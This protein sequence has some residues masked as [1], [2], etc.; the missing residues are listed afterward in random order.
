[1]K[2]DFFWNAWDK[3][4]KLFYKLLLILFGS[5]VLVYVLTIL[6]GSSFVINWEQETWI[7]PVKVLFA[8]YRLG[9]F[10]FPITIEN[11]A[12]SQSFV[13]SELQVNVWPAYI[14]L[15]W[16]GIFISIML[17]LITD[18]SRFWFVVSIVLLTV[19]FIGLKLDYLVLFNS[20][21][22][23]GLLVA[24]I[25]YYPALYIF[26]F[27]KKDIGFTVRFLTHLLATI[28]FGLIIFFFSNV[29]LPFF[30]VVN[31]GIYVPLVLTILFA[32]FVGHEIVSG[33]LRVITSGAMIGEKNGL[34]HFLVI[35]IVFLINA[36][37]VILRNSKILDLDIYLVGS[38][39]LLTIAAVVG[40]WGYRSR[41]ATYSGIFTFY[42]FGAFLFIGLAITA[43]FTISYF[44]ITGNDS[45]VEAIEDAIIFSQFGYSLIFVIYVIA[46]FFDLLKHNVDVGKVLYKPRRMPYFISRFAGIIVIM[47]LFFRFNMIPY[48]QSVAG[49]YAGI[50]DLYMEAKDHMSA[51]E[52]Y[53]LSNIFSNTSHRVNYALATMEKREGN[54]RQEIEFLQKAI[55]KNPTE[56]AYVNL[57]SR[58]ME[59]ERFFEAI[60]TLQDGLEKFPENGR[61][62]NNLGLVYQE[63]DNI[64][65]AYYYFEGAFY[66]D[67][68]T[69]VAAAN[70]YAMLS[71]KGLSIKYDTLDILLP[72][73]EDRTKVNN[74]VVLANNLKKSAND[75]YSI[76]FGK[77]DKLEVDQLVYN[78][79]KSINNPWL[80]DSAYLQQMQV[81]YDSSNTSW[82]QDNLRLSSALALYKQGELSKSLDLLNLLAIQ[83][84]EKGYFGLLGKLSL[85]SGEVGLAIDNF[86]NAFQNGQLEI[87]PELAFAYMEN[88]E[89]SKAEF[90]WEQLVLSGD[91]VNVATANKMLEVIK[92][93]SIEEVLET[94]TETRFSFLAYR[95]RE[96][97]LGKLEGL[98]LSFD[99]EDIQAMGFLRLFD[100]YLEL[101]QV[102]KAVDLL[103]E[104]GQLNISRQDVLEEINLA[105]CRYAY[106]TM[107]GEIMQRLYS[108]LESENQRVND[109]LSL[110]KIIEKSSTTGPQNALTEFEKLGRRNPFFEEGVIESVRFFNESIE[111]RDKAYE[112][113]LNAVNKNPFSIELNKLYAIQCLK[114]GLISYA[115][116]TK[117]ELQ[118]MMP[119][120]TFKVF[121]QEFNKIR[122]MIE[123][124]ES[125]W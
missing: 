63:I 71:C 57:A 49:F 10:E 2:P 13:A 46:N 17:A 102:Q 110:F 122:A 55:G 58:L 119:S 19:L 78:Y 81:F 35:S 33:F 124:I 15:L 42:P 68:T 96:F 52:Y 45:F 47:A 125:T 91:S 41:E 93:G 67:N 50:G 31:Y 29:N 99:N 62:L 53:K 97:D 100:A 117:D 106:H 6:A 76:Q 77:P 7:E 112:I 44:F 25:L 121:E 40:I 83:N 18:L 101:D 26:H 82:F 54:T 120:V 79:N 92:R 72:A 59:E 85:M 23:I 75:R 73:S 69:N 5:S 65:S 28:A 66:N 3:P 43:H 104:I 64:D 84:P 16:L 32:F 108:N 115:L 70:I 8:T 86:K 34:I 107:D 37:L 38:F 61:I 12:I 24:F 87:A 22:K 14:L 114:V 113:A 90:I 4:F 39:W 51:S 27:I 94:D 11:Y 123:S 60:F 1:M 89:L 88:G 9:V 21:E 105:Q 98:V 30:H 74:L 116:E 118:A 95:Y 56:F 109:Y 80:V 36:G 48:Y 103:Q 111:D 20:Y